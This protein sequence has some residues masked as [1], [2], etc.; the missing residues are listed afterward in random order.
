M[1]QD[2][3]DDSI[4]VTHLER[5]ECCRTR[6]ARSRT[7]AAPLHA[8]AQRETRTAAPRAAQ[9]CDGHTLL[10]LGARAS[11]SRR[12]LH[13]AGAALPQK[14]DTRHVLQSAIVVRTH[15]D[16]PARAKYQRAVCAAARQRGTDNSMRPHRAT[17]RPAC[18]A[19]ICAPACTKAIRFHFNNFKPCLT[20]FSK[21]FSSFARATCSLSVS[22]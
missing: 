19:L 12:C 2:G 16:Q 20:L 14:P 5:A 18:A 6:R 22:E 9:P 17:L 13:A 11:R 3:S 7:R 15:A 4:F 8:V 21:F 1:F 10:L